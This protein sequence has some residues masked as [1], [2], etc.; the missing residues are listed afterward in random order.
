VN[1]HHNS[2][3]HSFMHSF[4]LFSALRQ[5]HSLFLSQFPIQCNRVLHL[6]V[7]SIL[8]FLNVIQYSFLPRLPTTSLLSSIFPSIICFRRQFLRKVWPIQWAFLL[9]IFCR[10]FLSSL[11]IVTLFISHMIG[12]TDLH[13]SPVPLFKTLQLSLIY[14]AKCLSFSTIQSYIPN[15]ALH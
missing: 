4:V 15:V 13:P 5:F 8:F 10:V 2:F 7:S 1:L 12:S 3:I 14:F 6:S 9:F 11:T